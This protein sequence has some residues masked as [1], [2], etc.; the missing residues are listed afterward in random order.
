MRDEP[1]GC[2]SGRT[3]D[4]QWEL[5]ERHPIDFVRRCIHSDGC[6]VV[7]R[8]VTRG[9]PY[10]YPRSFSSNVSEDIKDIFCATCDMLGI[11]YHR[12]ARYVSVARQSDVAAP[13]AHGCQEW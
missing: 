12:T 5:L 11:G 13:D 9:K 2:R 4:W 3:S 10:A 7:N 8:V 1:G 6:R